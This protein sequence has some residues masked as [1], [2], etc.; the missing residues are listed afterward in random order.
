MPFWYI[1][2]GPRTHRGK[3]ICAG[4]GPKLKA[5]VS[6]SPLILYIRHL[7]KIE[8]NARRELEHYVHWCRELPL[9]DTY[10]AFG[11]CVLFGGGPKR[12]R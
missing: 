7:R 4:Y 11:G 6:R 10:F 1:P 5:F 9:G 8:F 3:T 12:I 2:Y